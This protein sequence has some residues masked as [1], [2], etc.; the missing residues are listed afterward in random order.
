MKK[1]HE[2]AP[3]LL[4]NRGKLHGVSPVPSVYRAVLFLR[5]DLRNE[6]LMFCSVG[7]SFR[8]LLLAPDP[9]PDPT[10]NPAVPVVLVAL[11]VAYRWVGVPVVGVVV[12][13]LRLPAVLL[14]LSGT[15]V[16]SSACSAALGTAGQDRKGKAHVSVSCTPQVS[17][18]QVLLAQRNHDRSPETLTIRVLDRL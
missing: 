1:P 15:G 14:A 2:R 10:T 3:L 4:Q 6:S 12:A 9:P 7:L 17:C 13:T 16:D 5:E 18:H 11:R 8:G